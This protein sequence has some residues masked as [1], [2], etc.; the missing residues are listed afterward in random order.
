MNSEK[1]VHANHR[2]RFID[3][4]LENPSSFAEHEL[5]E[6]LLYSV[7]VRKDTNEL[8]HKLLSYFGSLEKVFKADTSALM[9]I[10]GVGKRVAAHIKTI[11]LIYEHMPKNKNE[12]VTEGSS[13]VAIKNKLDE[14]F[15]NATSEKFLLMLF[16][17]SNKLLSS[18][19]YN[20]NQ[21]H[22]VMISGAQI[23]EAINIIKPSYAIIAHN[24][25][26]DNPTP[27][28]HDDIATTKLNILLDLHSVYLNDHV[29]VAKNNKT[30]SYYHS[31]RLQTIKEKCTI[32]KMIAHLKTSDG[33]LL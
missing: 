13:F 7:I 25:L 18:L 30:Y 21:F 1:N 26:T 3:K 19:E 17:K 9:K 33:E 27:S 32:D 31:G 24:H 2:Q 20:N 4:F 29:I 10:S 6:I 8:A 22:T 23:V 5:L 15:Y 11:G 14:T 16:D 28:S 12:K